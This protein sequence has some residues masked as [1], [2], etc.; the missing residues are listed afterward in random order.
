MAKGLLF[1]SSPVL[2]ASLLQRIQMKFFVLNSL[3]F[4]KGNVLKN[5][6]TSFGFISLKSWTSS[7]CPSI[8]YLSSFSIRKKLQIFIEQ[9]FSKFTLGSACDSENL[10]SNSI[11]RQN[12][13]KFLLKS[14]KKKRY[15]RVKLRTNW[16]FSVDY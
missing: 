10:D 16:F 14:L 2:N 3:I 8:L 11:L 12:K 15:S 7:K 4:L 9:K 1:N 13:P 6:S 5:T